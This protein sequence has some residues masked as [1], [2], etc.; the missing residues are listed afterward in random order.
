MVWDTRILQQWGFVTPAQHATGTGS[1]TGSQ[2]GPSPDQAG[3]FPDDLRGQGQGHH[4]QGGSGVGA[5][6]RQDISPSMDDGYG[7]MVAAPDPYALDGGGH[8]VFLDG[9]RQSDA[10]SLL[11]AAQEDTL[12]LFGRGPNG[13]TRGSRC[14]MSEHTFALIALF[15]SCTVAV[16]ALALQISF[17]AYANA[18]GSSGT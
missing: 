9:R 7:Y 2:A 5:G 12:S 17:T 6:S 11:S 15:A 10:H 14:W 8:A 16:S 4:G 1:G 18:S 13:R 3:Y